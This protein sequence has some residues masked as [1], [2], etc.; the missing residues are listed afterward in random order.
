MKRRKGGMKRKRVSNTF[1][2]A[3]LSKTSCS[4]CQ[5]GDNSLDERCSR[6]IIKVKISFKKANLKMLKKREVI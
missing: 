5:Y 4:Y 2:K 3:P 1:K 6:C